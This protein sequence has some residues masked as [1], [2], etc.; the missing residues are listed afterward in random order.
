MERLVSMRIIFKIRGI[1]ACGIAN[2]NGSVKTNT[3]TKE[4]RGN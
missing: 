4:N 2:R 3:H 1:V